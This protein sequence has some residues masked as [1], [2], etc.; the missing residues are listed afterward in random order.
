MSSITN[1]LKNSSKDIQ[2]AGKNEYNDIGLLKHSTFYW[3]CLIVTILLSYGFA[4][5]NHSTGIDDIHFDVYFDNHMLATSGRWGYIPIMYIFR[6]YTF[7]PFWVDFLSLVLMATGVSLYCGI[8]RRYTQGLLDEYASIIFATTMVSFPWIAHIFVYMTAK[9]N[10]SLILIFA[11]ISLLFACKWFV[12]KKI[13][14]LF[15]SALSLAYS[16][17]FYEVAIV[18]FLVSCFSVVLL[19]F[20][21]DSDLKIKDF[22]ILTLKIVAI[23]L[24]ALVIWRLVGISILWWFSVDAWDYTAGFVQY[25]FTDAQQFIASLTIFLQ[26]FVRLYVFFPDNGDTIRIIVWLASFVVLLFGL[27]FAVKLKS[28]T[29]LLSSVAIVGSAYSLFIITGNPFLNVRMIYTFSMLISVALVFL[30][31]LLVLLVTNKQIIKGFRHVILFVVLWIVV[32]NTREMNSIF[33][34]DY[35]RYQRDIMIAQSLIQDLQNFDRQKPIIF[36]GFIPDPLGDVFPGEFTGTSLF[37][38]VRNSNRYF[39]ISA[40]GNNQLIHFFHHYHFP[41]TAFPY[42]VDVNEFLIQI[43]DMESWPN[44][45]YIREFENY[46]I[47]RLGSSFWDS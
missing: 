9:I 17:A 18:F 42:P 24:T 40:F 14:F 37:N 33:Y 32:F 2:I 28:V 15:I 38:F 23:L 39:E 34:V 1:F 30:Y 45:G 8:F 27:F 29:I 7:L 22:C 43:S 11:A 5:T 36:L 12:E 31:V 20:V 19:L 16:L 3:L 46:I 10:I 35:Q 47:V 44:H 21:S 41:I 6:P 13:K 4:L 25:N 26:T